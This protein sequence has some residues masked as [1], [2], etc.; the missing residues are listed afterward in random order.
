MPFVLSSLAP[1]FHLP[2]ALWSV[3]LNSGNWRSRSLVNSLNGEHVLQS[4]LAGRFRLL[5]V[6]DAVREMFRLDRELIWMFLGAPQLDGL[7]T[8]FAMQPET[9]V[10]KSGLHHQIAGVAVDSE[11]A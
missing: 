11:N 9:F 10:V 1:Y 8:G 7:S 3:P 2:C 4:F 5:V 6:A